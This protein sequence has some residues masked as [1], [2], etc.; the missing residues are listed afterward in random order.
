MRSGSQSDF[1]FGIASIG[2][3]LLREGFLAALASAIA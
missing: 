1:D 2:G 3:F